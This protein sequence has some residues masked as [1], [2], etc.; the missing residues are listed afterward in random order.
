[1][2]IADVAR[3]T[4]K[5]EQSVRRAI[6][7]RKLKATL[8]DGHYEIEEKDISEWVDYRS[9]S[10]NNSQPIDTD[11]QAIVVEN[12]TLK[13]QIAELQRELELKQK[14]T[15]ELNQIHTERIDDLK[16]QV[17]EKDQQIN[18]QQAII[19]QLSRNQ[20]LMLE[21]TEQ[22]AKR[23]WWSRLFRKAS[24]ESN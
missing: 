6:K 24:D 20:Q 19:M 9:D 17:E 23:G 12:E 2:T 22:K 18:Q 1:L 13:R 14:R 21:S 16:H 10:Q 7:A 8:V 11:S 4:G 15:E 3:I 5:S